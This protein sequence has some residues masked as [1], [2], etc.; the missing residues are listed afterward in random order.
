MPRNLDWDPAKQITD[1]TGKVILVTGG[2]A[3]LGRET[4]LSFAA[5]SPAHIYFTGRSQGSADKLVSDLKA[6]YAD[7]QVTF[8]QCDLASLASVQAAATRILAQTDRLDI[9]ILNAGMLA[10]S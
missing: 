2:T 8:V 7:V 6:Q 4:V 3:G 9:A 10:C 5:H 1:L